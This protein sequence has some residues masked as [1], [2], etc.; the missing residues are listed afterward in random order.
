MRSHGSDAAGPF[1]SPRIILIPAILRL[2]LLDRRSVLLRGIEASLLQRFMAGMATL[3]AAHLSSVPVSLWLLLN[4]Q[5]FGST[6]QPQCS[7]AASG[8]VHTST[9]L[10]T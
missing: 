10:V 3:P 8:I 1:H 2:V 7:T 4:A 5:E 9:L 6:M